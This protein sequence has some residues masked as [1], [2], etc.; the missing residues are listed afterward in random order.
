MKPT[1]P[2]MGYIAYMEK[3][4]PFLFEDGILRLFP[5]TREDWRKRRRSLFQNLQELKA[6]CQAQEWVGHS[7]L[8]GRTHDG[9]SIVFSVSDLS[10]NDNGFESFSVDYHFKYNVSYLDDEQIYGF[11]L[12]GKDVDRFIIRG[13][14]L[15]RTYRAMNWGYRELGYM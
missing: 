11:S 8:K 15:L 14:C 7:R 3:E 6:K 5:P 2:L 10:S 12:T 1:S 4:Y 13:V 9:D